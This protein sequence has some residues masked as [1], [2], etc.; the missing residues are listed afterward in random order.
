MKE[1]SFHE[2]K[3]LIPPAGMKDLLK[4]YISTTRKTAFNGRNI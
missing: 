3:I 2:T 4:E 1:Y